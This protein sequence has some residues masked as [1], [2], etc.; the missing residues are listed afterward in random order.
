MKPLFV[1][2]KSEYEVGLIQK[3]KCSIPFNFTFFGHKNV[4][5]VR[6]L[7]DQCQLIECKD[8]GKRF[9]INHSVR[10]ILPWNSVSTFYESNIMQG[11]LTND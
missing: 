5:V 7:S 2:L 10:T 3:I 1:P 8:C 6:E 4:S 11:G 9:A